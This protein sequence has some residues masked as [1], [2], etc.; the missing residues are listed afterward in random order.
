[1]TVRVGYARV[2]TLKT[3]QDQSIEGQARELRKAG[4][5]RVISERGS[6]FSGKQRPGWDELWLLVAT[7]QVREVLTVDQSRLSRSGE[8]K[9]FLAHCAKFGAQVRTL[10]TGIVETE[11]YGGFLSA[12]ISSVINEAQSRLQGAKVRD[13]IRRRRDAGFLAT[14]RMPFGYRHKN[15][16]AVPDPKAWQQARER[17]DG[18]MRMEMNVGGWIR[19]TKTEIT[20]SGVKGWLDHP[21]LRGAVRGQWGQVEPLI[22]WQEWEQAK[23]LLKAR[24]N[25]RGR[26]AG[27]VRLFTGLVK[28]S[29]CGKNLHNGAESSRNPAVWLRCKSIHCDYFGRGIRESVARELVIQ[30]LVNA[31][32][33]VAAADGFSQSNAE[34]SAVVELRAQIAQLEELQAQGVPGLDEVIQRQREQVTAIKGVSTA[35]RRQLGLAMCALPEVISAFSEDR[36][37][38]LI[39]EFVDQVEYSG[40]PKHLKINLR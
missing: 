33:A 21:M 17:F 20:L 29:K 6:A 19:E 28:C 26:S 9:A 13:G 2:S 18:L 12:S 5:D 7:G 38:S 31:S 36:L 37:R 25:N 3:E 4:C 16:K 24:A 22:S 8:D 11:S 10:A 35:P 34:P 15:G 1:V 14:A 32:E 40:S 27:S 39:I 30:A 23:A